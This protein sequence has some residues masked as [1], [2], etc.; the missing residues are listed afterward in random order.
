MSEDAKIL[1]AMLHLGN[2][3]KIE[4]ID[5]TLE[6][7]KYITYKEAQ[8]V[9]QILEAN[10]IYGETKLQ[11]DKLE[12]TIQM[13]DRYQLEADDLMSALGFY[14]YDV[15]MSDDWNGLTGIY[16]SVRIYKKK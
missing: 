13:E 10:G 1:E 14:K 12:V 3:E 7:K 16:T 4:G 11:A 2:V 15:R 9:K 8:K 5:K 6:D